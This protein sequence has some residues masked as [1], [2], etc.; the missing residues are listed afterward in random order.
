MVN[1]LLANDSHSLYHGSLGVDH[2]VWE[3]LSGHISKRVG[4]SMDK[5]N[6]GEESSYAVTN[7]MGIGGRSGNVCNFFLCFVFLPFLTDLK[8]RIMIL[9]MYQHTSDHSIGSTFSFIRDFLLGM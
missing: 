5:V 9:Q 7:V 4:G 6:T 2:L 1:V 8:N 3:S